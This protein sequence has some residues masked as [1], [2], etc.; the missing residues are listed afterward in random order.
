MNKLLVALGLAAT[1]SG[2]TGAHLAA[3]QSPAAAAYKRDVPARLLAQTKISGTPPERSLSRA[4]RE[5]RSRR[6]SSSGRAV[7]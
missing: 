4:C 6:S 3:Q 5:P 7:A 1:L 2:I